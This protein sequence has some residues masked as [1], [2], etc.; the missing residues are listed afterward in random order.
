MDRDFAVVQRWTVIW[1][2]DDMRQKIFE[3]PHPASRIVTF[4][5]SCT[6]APVE[7]QFKA[8]ARLRCGGIICHPDQF[9]RLQ[10][11]PR[12]RLGDIKRTE[13]RVCV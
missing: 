9:E 11:A 12:L 2:R 4:S 10:D 13:Q 6:L 5:K 7:H 3:A 8:R 1:P